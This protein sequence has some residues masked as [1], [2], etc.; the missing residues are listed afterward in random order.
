MPRDG[1]AKGKGATAKGDDAD[2]TSEADG[3]GEEAAVA[4]TPAGQ[5]SEV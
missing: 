5:D 4:A 2:S 3:A 1:A